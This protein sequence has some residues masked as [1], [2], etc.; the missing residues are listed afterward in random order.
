LSWAPEWTSWWNSEGKEGQEPPEEIKHIWSLCDGLPFLPKEE[1]DKAAKEILSFEAKNL[2][3]VG[4]VGMM[5]KPCIANVNLGNV[6]T[7][8]FAD[9]SDN[10]G[11]RNNWLEEWFWKE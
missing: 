7:N 5:G 2:F 1:R 10:A 4:T 6:N 3:F 8:A 11:N 9:N